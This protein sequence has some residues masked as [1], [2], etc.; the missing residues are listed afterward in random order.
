[1]RMQLN[2]AHGLASWGG[3]IDS[4]DV[5]GYSWITP[6]ANKNVINRNERYDYR[7]RMPTAGI[8]EAIREGVWLRLLCL[9]PANWYHYSHAF[10]CKINL[11]A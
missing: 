3:V 8:R 5:I 6:I 9:G 11:D 1:M 10:P 2:F 7:P 4:L